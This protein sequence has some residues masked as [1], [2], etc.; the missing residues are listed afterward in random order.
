[1]SPIIYEPLL[2]KATIKALDTVGRK[3][4][5]ATAT[6]ENAVT[7]LLNRWNAM[8]TEEK[9]QVATIIIATTTTAVAAIAA[10]KGGKKRVAKKVAKKVMKRV[11]RR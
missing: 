8:T 6:T 2:R 9:E 3:F 11:V 1:M 7:R 5:G 10:I 4:A